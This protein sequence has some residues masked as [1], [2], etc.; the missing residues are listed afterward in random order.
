MESDA[1]H[2]SEQEL[3]C[4]TESVTEYAAD[5]SEQELLCRA[6][7]VTECAA[8]TDDLSRNFRADVPRNMLQAPRER[9]TVKLT[10]CP[11]AKGPSEE[12]KM[13]SRPCFPL[14]AL[15]PRWEVPPSVDKLASR[16]RQALWRAAADTTATGLR[17]PLHP[18]K[19]T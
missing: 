5:P 8:D 1:P 7:A 12:G 17:R 11:N 19:R 10:L 2:L 18:S 3:L 14:Q 15:F 4:R 6:E 16:T 13:R 9:R